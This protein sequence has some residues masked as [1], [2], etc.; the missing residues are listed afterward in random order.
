[1]REQK[2]I[3]IFHPAIAPYRI[4][5][6]NEISSSY[7]TTICLY[8]RNLKSQQFDYEKIES[9][10]AFIPHYFNK[11][12]KFG[13]RTFYLGHKKWINRIKPDIII[14][15]EYGLGLWIAFINRVFLPKK[16]KIL[17]ICD[18]SK[19]MAQKRNGLRKLARDIAVRHLDGIILC[20]YDAAEWYS[21]YGT[22]TYVFPIIQDEMDFYS[23]KELVLERA[24]Q[25][26]CE[27][28]LHRK[29]I[30]LYVG[31]LSPEKNL[32]YLI[33][34][35]INQH[36]ENP[37][38]ILFVIGGKSISDP[39]LEERLKEIIKDKE[40]GDYIRIIGRK[41]GA[42]L[43]AWYFLGQVLLL[44]SKEEAFGAVVNEALLAGEYVM[45]SKVA[46]AACL[47]TEKNGILLDITEPF[48]SFKKINQ[49]VEP[50][51]EDIQIRK[52]KMPFTFSEKMVGLL[53]WL[54]QL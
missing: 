52:S 14:V 20:N 33:H 35:F 8:Y 32:P 15:S 10:F 43:K 12:I 28:G 19:K 39:E 45:V 24:K 50:L 29:K 1:M 27:Y 21:Q 51:K 36:T 7:D 5:F 6:F 41:E 49:I 48:I 42:E 2:K 37:E 23:D 26:C 9:Q 53:A 16:Y 46:G 30:F 13:R 40:A 18:D 25:L 38:N 34:S 3:L 22:P 17:T 44:P 4:R 47:V 54:D 11:W 31:R